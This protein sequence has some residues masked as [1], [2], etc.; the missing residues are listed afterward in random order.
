MGATKSRFFCLA[1]AATLAALLVV[2][3]GGRNAARGQADADHFWTYRWTAPTTGSPV[4]YYVVEYVTN[5]RDTTRIDRVAGLSVNIPV[6]LG[7]DYVVLV[8]GVDAAGRMGPFSVPSIG[9]TFEEDPPT[10]T[11]GS[12]S[13][14]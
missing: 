3:A 9:E 4:A 7:N 1:G 13:G 5:G 10:N 12:G 6:E 8:A 2:F 14:Q 11:S